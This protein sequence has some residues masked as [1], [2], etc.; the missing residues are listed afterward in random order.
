MSDNGNS[1]EGAAAVVEQKFHGGFFCTAKNKS[2]KRRKE[3][4]LVNILNHLFVNKI[5]RDIEKCS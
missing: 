5:Y 2:E 3:M 4:M 1:V